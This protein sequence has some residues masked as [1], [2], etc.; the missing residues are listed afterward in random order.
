MFMAI[1]GRHDGNLRAY[2]QRLNEKQGGGV[3]ISTQS[4]QT[5]YAAC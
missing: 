1:L 5:P 4:E 2:I 3:L